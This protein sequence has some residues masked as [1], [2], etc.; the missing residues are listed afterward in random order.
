MILCNWPALSGS[1]SVCICR[2]F[3]S[4]CQYSLRSNS[5]LLLELDRGAAVR[6]RPR[7]SKLRHNDRINGR[8]GM[9][10]SNAQVRT[11]IEEST[12]SNRRGKTTPQHQQNKSTK[13][14]QVSIQWGN[15][16]NEGRDCLFEFMRGSQ[17]GRR[18]ATNQLRPQR[19]QQHHERSSSSH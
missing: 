11:L 9:M 5:S 8:E 18:G 10:N 4:M 7:N 17:E 3:F 14:A 6:D 13:A 19:R 15:K 16:Q 1:G 12:G 2:N